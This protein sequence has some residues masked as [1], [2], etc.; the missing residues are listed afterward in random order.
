MIAVI[1]W[2][3][4]EQLAKALVG[5]EVMGHAPFPGFR[6][7]EQIL[8]LRRKDVLKSQSAA[9]GKSQE[10]GESLSRQ[11]L[12]GVMV[13]ERQKDRDGSMGFRKG[14]KASPNVAGQASEIPTERREAEVKRGPIRTGGSSQRIEVPRSVRYGGL[15]CR[16]K[17]I[18]LLRN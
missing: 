16:G 3:S 4:T 7:Y 8:K 12:L 5:E 11:R 2:R 14:G 10:A 17:S 15:V 6:E 13:G 1:Q 18:S 9:R